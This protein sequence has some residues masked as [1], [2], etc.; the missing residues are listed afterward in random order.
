MVHGTRI[1]RV[2]LPGA[3]TAT[4]TV[5]LLAGCLSAGQPDDSGPG[6]R[7]SDEDVHET[8]S[9]RQDPE[10]PERRT[11]PLI[12]I[13]SV[14]LQLQWISP[15]TVILLPTQSLITDVLRDEPGTIVGVD[16]TEFRSGRI[17]LLFNLNTTAAP[18][19]VM[20]RD[21]YLYPELYE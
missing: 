2:F 20:E 9:P 7:S 5:L 15:A 16:D 6:E 17:R 4:L 19:F 3:L 10:E 8:G 14:T 21:R 1:L 12:A 13:N 11:D 18:P